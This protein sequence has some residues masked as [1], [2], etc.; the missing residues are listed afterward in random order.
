MTDYEIIEVVRAHKEGKAIQARVLESSPSY[1]FGLDGRWMTLN[2]GIWDFA[3]CEYRVA[4]EPRKPREWWAEFP[5]DGR[6][7]QIFTDFRQ[8][9]KGGELIRV[10][11]VI[12]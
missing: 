7:G 8:L 1:C 2:V 11:E 10:R 4:P 12:D 9:T 5:L 3:N 6:V